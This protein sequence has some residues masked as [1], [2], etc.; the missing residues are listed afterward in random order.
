MKDGWEEHGSPPGKANLATR[1]SSIKLASEVVGRV[2]SV[3]TSFL[4]I[5]ALSVESFGLYTAL[6]GVAVI[7]AEVADLGLQGTA[8]RALVARS[9]TL[10]AMLRAKLAL[11][12]GLGIFTV[13]LPLLA[14]LAAPVLL[15]LLPASWRVASLA[16]VSWAQLLV[17]LILYFIVAGWG[18]F[19][20]VA[21]R[22]FGHRIEEALVML[23]L[24]GT[25]LCGVLLAI[26]RQAGLWGL[27]WV[28]VLSMLPPLLLAWILTRRA[29]GP[30][31]AAEPEG[32]PLS[33]VLKAALPLAVNGGLALVSLR[34]EVL[35]VFFLRGPREAGLLGA[36]LKVVESLNAF[37]SAINAGAMPFLTGEALERSGAMG[38]ADE[39]ARRSGP[40][41]RRT[42]ASVALLAVPSAVGLGLLAPGVLR[43]LGVGYED[44]TALL[45]ILAFAVVALFMNSLLFHALI[46]AGRA[47]TLPRLTA[48]RVGMATVLAVTLI[49]AFGAVGAAVGFVTSEGMLL[50]FATRACRRASFDVPVASPLG[51]A[52]CV[53]V[54]MAVAVGLAGKGAMAGAALGI[55]V[56]AATLAAAWFLLPQRLLGALGG[57]YS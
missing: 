16:E 41:R 9:F 30:S 57:R 49:P 38:S 7:L 47:S 11:T 4:I 29:Q 2:I 34:L 31:V 27:A 32:P 3:V 28:H 14:S 36:A 33:H 17:P 46:A 1:G 35:L 42:S 44:S 43:L 10:R 56:Y 19:L 21:L 6:S 52:V 12:I 54:P 39:G 51:W 22:A 40:V 37:P 48:L 53:S 25:L 23:F 18:E 15:P 50:V 13:S 26:Q 8:N 5:R 24:R 55:L 45:R 20:G